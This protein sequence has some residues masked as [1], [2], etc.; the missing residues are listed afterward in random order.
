MEIKCP[1]CHKVFCLQH[2]HQP[3]HSCC[4]LAS[5]E[6]ATS[7]RARERPA[8]AAAVVT[9]DKTSKAEK[10]TVDTTTNPKGVCIGLVCVVYCTS[11][12][13]YISFLLIDL[14]SRSLNPSHQFFF[15]CAL[16]SITCT[17]VCHSCTYLSKFLTCP[18]PGYVCTCSCRYTV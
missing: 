13:I 11:R 14:R 6:R 10:T 2:R 9:T 4:A 7:S 5:N 18:W 16:F 15:G 3:N 17:P 12:C 1:Y 8:T